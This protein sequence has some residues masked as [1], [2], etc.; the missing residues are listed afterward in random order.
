MSGQISIEKIKKHLAT[1][2]AGMFAFEEEASIDAVVISDNKFGQYESFM[3]IQDETAGIRLNFPSA[4]TYDFGDSLHIKLNNL[5]VSENKQGIS[6]DIPEDFKGITLVKKGIQP[7]AISANVNYLSTYE[8]RYVVFEGYQFDAELVGKSF[9]TEPAY[10]YSKHLLQ[11]CNA[12]KALPLIIRNTPS[13]SNA[14]IPEGKGKLYGIV[15][16]NPY[17]YLQIA[18]ISSLDMNEE[19]CDPIL[20]SIEDIKALYE[21]DE[22]FAEITQNCY[23]KATISMN[24][25]QQNSYKKLQLQDK[26]AGITIKVD[27]TNIY[28]T[29][30]PG[31][32]IN[33][34]LKGLFI[35]TYGGMFSLGEKEG[36]K[37][38]G[39]SLYDMK[40]R[41][42]DADENAPIEALSKEMNE[43]RPHMIGKLVELKN[44]QFIAAELGKTYADKDATTNRTIANKDGIELDIRTSNYATFADN[45]IPS[46]SGSIT[47]ILTTYHGKYQMKIRDIQEVKLTEPRF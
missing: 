46:E 17:N 6:I 5:R 45:E 32:T 11:S 43:L 28:N 31:R 36:D 39:I 19:R 23:I 47:G 35:N 15:I 21:G 2:G 16:R 26:T 42:S 33:I 7:K 14:I 30:Y 27:A 18:S 4:H 13:F 22:E 1:E 8:D 29:F 9:V 41:V 38:I 25:E 12:S 10:E 3:Y 37:L 34:N 24:N 40:N 44:V 20:K